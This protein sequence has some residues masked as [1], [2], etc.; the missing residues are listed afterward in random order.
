MQLDKHAGFNLHQAAVIEGQY[1][2][3]LKA[4]GLP[5]YRSIKGL[6]YECAK[7]NSR[8]TKLQWATCSDDE[9]QAVELVLNDG[10]AI[11]ARGSDN[12]YTELHCK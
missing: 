7:D 6:Y 9:E 10:A 11:N 2:V 8:Q 12:D 4:H 3:A 5:S 1:D